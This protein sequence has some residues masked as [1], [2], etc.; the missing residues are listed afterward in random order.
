MSMTNRFTEA[1]QFGS[2]EYADSI[3]AGTLN[4]GWV[5]EENFHRSVCILIVGDMAQGATLDLL[6]QEA[7]DAAGTGVQA[8]AGKAITQ[9][10]AAGGDG[11]QVCV[12]EL[13]SEELDIANGFEFV[14][15]QLVIANA[16][17]ELAI[18]FLQGAPTRYWPVPVT[19]LQEV[20]D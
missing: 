7:Q 9:L 3:G 1:Y 8:I 4:G 15:W 20:V 17:V 19:Q 2:V 16:A 10:T 13:R 14:R 12:I 18:A 5:N 6:L 11:D